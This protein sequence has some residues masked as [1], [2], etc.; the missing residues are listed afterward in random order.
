MA[1]RP[2]DANHGDPHGVDPT[3]LV[4]R[5]RAIC[6]A[7]PEVTERPSHGTPTWFVRG[8][9]TFVTIWPYG[10]HEDEFA[11]MW[12]AAPPGAQQELIAADPDRYHY[13]KYVGH[14]GWVGVRLHAPVDWVELA[15]I[16]EEAYRAVAPKTLVAKLDASR[17]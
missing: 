12:C 13:P 3:A 9:T 4:A 7:L 10:H 11:H 15:E 17:S 16:L 1:Q 5:V 8:K 2:V 6:S 14:R